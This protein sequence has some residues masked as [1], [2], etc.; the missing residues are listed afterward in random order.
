MHL[1]AQAANDTKAKFDQLANAW[2]ENRS[3]HAMSSRTGIFLNGPE[4]SQI[5]A[6][7]PAIIPFALERY[8]S[9]SWPWAFVLQDITGLVFVENANHFATDQ[10]R[11]LVTNWYEALSKGGAAGPFAC[12]QS[13]RI[14]SFARKPYWS[15]QSKYNYTLPTSKP[16]ITQ[17]CGNLHISD[18]RAS[19]KSLDIQLTWDTPVKP[20]EKFSL[21]CIPWTDIG[22]G[23]VNYGLPEHYDPTGLPR[24]YIE[25]PFTSVSSDGSYKKDY[26]FSSDRLQ[27]TTLSGEVLWQVRMPPGHKAV[28]YAVHNNL[29]FI[30]TNS[31]QGGRDGELLSPYLTTNVYGTY[32][33]QRP[34][35]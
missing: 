20:A 29:L 30:A 19:D 23:K 4:M 8:Q 16:L 22:R 28:A 14:E 10:L 5:V 27:K 15:V 35:K 13:G 9:E 25:D 6:M 32:L 31:D 17:P 18:L 24:G 7:G 2:A 12:V 1:P 26:V 3:K 21:A 11:W 33:P 34:V